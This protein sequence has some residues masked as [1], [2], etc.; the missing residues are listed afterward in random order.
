MVLKINREVQKRLKPG[1]MW[2]DMEIICDTM[3]I[4]ELKTLG[5]IKGDTKTLLS[6]NVN[7]LFMPH[8]L[9]HFIVSYYSLVGIR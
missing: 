9:G 5:F 6:L 2:S 4:E 8:G 1:V 3:L 7:L